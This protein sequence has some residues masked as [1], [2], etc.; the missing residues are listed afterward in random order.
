[1]TGSPHTY[2]LI[3]GAWHGGWCWTPVARSLEEAGHTVHAPTMA[4]HGPGGDR[5][6]SHEDA[7]RSLV[8]HVTQHEL[9]DVVLV[10]HSW[11]GYILACAAPLM[12]DRLHGVIGLNAL[13]PEH[14]Q[15][16]FDANDPDVAQGYRDLSAAAS[17]KSVMLDWDRFRGALIQTAPDPIARFA[18]SLMTPVPLSCFSGVPDCAG[19]DDLPLRRTY[20][21]GT[22]DIAMSEENWALFA[23][24]LRAERTVEFDGDHEALLT[25]PEVVAAAILEATPN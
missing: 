2:V 1:M 11:G 22:A 25:A 6:A 9:R 21:K 20:V 17:D 13:I 18:Y 24:R 12:A 14:G 15:C 8:D 5:S 4:G 10:A 19:L 23:D 16:M 7:V 3:H